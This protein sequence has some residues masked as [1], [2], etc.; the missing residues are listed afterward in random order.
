MFV[1]DRLSGVTSL[2]RSGAVCALRRWQRVRAGRYAARLYVWLAGA[3][4]TE[5]MLAHA[6]PHTASDADILIGNSL[7]LNV[8]LIKSPSSLTL[9][10]LCKF[11]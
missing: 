9:T 8:N 10:Q 5:P 11:E 4:A 2:V 6:Y 1:A 3:L 7:I